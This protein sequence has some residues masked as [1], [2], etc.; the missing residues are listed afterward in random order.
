M[1][2]K[3]HRRRQQ[4]PQTCRVPLIHGNQDDDDASDLIAELSREIT[5]LKAELKVAQATA[6]VSSTDPQLDTEVFET[7]LTALRDE[8]LRLKDA[9]RDTSANLEREQ[10]TVAE[11]ERERE[12]QN[13]SLKV[14]HQQLELERSR[15]AANG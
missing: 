4:G 8:T 15:K 14:L 9:L 11:L 13:K 7:E 3:T 2:R 6:P 1:G 5:S 10:S 12:L